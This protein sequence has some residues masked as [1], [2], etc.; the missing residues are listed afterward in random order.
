MALYSNVVIFTPF[1]LENFTSHYSLLF[2][3]IVEFS[4]W[5]GQKMLIFYNSVAVTA[6]QAVIQTRGL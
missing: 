4:N 3:S 2:P 1:P 6:I 5:I